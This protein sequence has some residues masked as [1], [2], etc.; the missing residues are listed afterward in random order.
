LETEETT[1]LSV[2]EDENRTTAAT[3]D[4]ATEQI[5]T[6]DSDNSTLTD[7]IADRAVNLGND[8]DELANTTSTGNAIPTL[9]TNNPNITTLSNVNTTNENLTNLT[10]GTTDNSNIAAVNDISSLEVSDSIASQVS[11]ESSTPAFTST[12][13]PAITST[14]TLSTITGSTTSNSSGTPQQGFSQSSI[15]VPFQTSN[16]REQYNTTVSKR[17]DPTLNNGTILFEPQNNGTDD[18]TTAE[19][20]PEPEIPVGDGVEGESEVQAVEEVCST[21]R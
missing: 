12:T 6:G 1:A 9:G 14:A 3:A 19:G 15:E 17:P 21:L 11:G 7:V 18:S 10:R 16:G 4:N 13:A 8:T 2:Q 20:L 5:P